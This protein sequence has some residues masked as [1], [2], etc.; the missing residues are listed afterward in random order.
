MTGVTTPSAAGLRER[1][2]QRTREALIA[3]AFDLFGRNGFEATT[4]EEIAEAV[5]VSPRTF[6]RYFA[7]KEDCALSMLDEQAEAMWAAFDARPAH[8][9][10]LTALK[11][12]MLV[13][14]RA[15]EEGKG[16][17]PIRFACMQDM[18]KNSPAV[19]AKSMEHGSMKMDGFAGRIAA[20]M[21]V[22][23]ATDPRP[24][25]VAAIV[26]TTVPL[27]I[28]VW[29][30]AEPETPLSTLVE[31]AFGLLEQGLNYP[32]AAAPPQAPSPPQ[33]PPPPSSPSPSKKRR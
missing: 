21:G 22:D 1:K 25:L 6:F 24:H 5:E 7:T 10:V 19:A 2:K 27:S 23:P 28:R 17:D 3:A 32:A 8:E 16:F 15:T 33:A 12:A 18:T 30:T 20:R 13:V 9:P 14:A 29:G 11:Q 4:V 26:V 31:R